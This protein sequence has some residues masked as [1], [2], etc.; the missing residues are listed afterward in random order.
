MRESLPD[1]EWWLKQGMKIVAVA[2]LSL[3]VTFGSEALTLGRSRGA[4]L[5]GR[6]LDV[7]V[8][9]QMDAGEDAASLCFEADVFDGDTRQD[10]SRVRVLIEAAAEPRMANLR[11]LSSVPVDEPVVTVYL[12]TGCGQ[13]TSRRYVL[14]ADFP[15][16]VLAPAVPQ[17][18]AGPALARVNVSSVAAVSAS[19][20]VVPVPVAKGK[21]VRAPRQAVRPTLDSKR[22]A[23]K[24]AVAPSR[25]A[26]PDERSAIVR[27]VGQSRLKLDPLELLSD[28]VSNLDSDMTFPA[29]PDALL[30][31][32]KV[33]MLEKEVKALVALTAKNEARL[34]DLQGR[35]G[36]AESERFSSALVYGLIAFAL[37]CLTAVAI[38]WR[39]QRRANPED[40]DWWSGSIRTPTAATTEISTDPP[41]G[42]QG[43][44]Q[45]FHHASL[46]EKQHIEEA[47]RLANRSQSAAIV[48]VNVTEMSDSN[49]D[50]FMSAGVTKV[51]E[52][53]SLPPENA[54]APQAK[55]V[56][57]F[58][59]EPVQDVRQRGEFF[60]SLGQT[61]RAVRVLR[62]QIG[63]SGEP[64]PLI[65]LD[66]LSILH[67]L[68]SKVEF[69]QLREEFNSTFN[70]NISQYVLFREEGR[71]LEAYPEILSLISAVWST[72]RGL[73]QIETYIIQNP[74]E[75]L[76]QSFD[77]AAFRD[78]LMLHAVAWSLVFDVDSEGHLPYDAAASVGVPLKPTQGGRLAGHALDLDLSDLENVGHDSNI[79]LAGSADNEVRPK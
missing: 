25:G 36:Q 39:R 23:S 41:T 8:P 54:I 77:L 63:E 4:V 33:Q 58:N 11:V 60:V 53:Q 43:V 47:P 45:E 20:L 15:S 75:A 27:P 22:A 65:Y 5:I 9:V 14:L 72:P 28:R 70:G 44:H 56:Q 61:E 34:V 46:A 12:R 10:A 49:F 73:A 79:G 18:M 64:N 76:G 62:K 7:V 38:L 17:P 57:R 2:L 32:Q 40:G 52:R 30:N 67:A 16:E 68:G 1:G 6:P 13:K 51:Q 48:D 19:S 78:L 37:T 29:P 3:G 74:R 42:P 24:T 31:L 69:Q 50:Q 21:S 35:L 59:S 55:P 26:T 71:D 66:L